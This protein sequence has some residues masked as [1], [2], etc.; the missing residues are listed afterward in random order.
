[1]LSIVPRR[2]LLSRILPIV[3]KLGLTGRRRERNSEWER[4]I[5]LGADEDV[6]DRQ[7]YVKLNSEKPQISI[8]RALKAD[9]SK[10]LEQFILDQC[11][12]F[13]VLQ[14]AR[15]LKILSRGEL[16]EELFKPLRSTQLAILRKS[17]EP[18]TNSSVHCMLLESV[19][20]AKSLF[21]ARPKLMHDA[22][23]LLVRIRPFVLRLLP[24]CAV[25]KQVVCCLAYKELD[26]CTP[27]MIAVLV[28]S[29]NGKDLT[30]DEGLFEYY[31]KDEYVTE[32]LFFRA[33][34]LL[35]YAAGLG[36]SN[37][38]VKD[39]V[40]KF[41]IGRVMDLDRIQRL[42][43]D[44]IIEELK[45]FNYSNLF[46]NEE[47]TKMITF[48]TITLYKR[49]VSK[50]LDRLDFAKHV[51]QH[52]SYISPEV[53]R[54]LLDELLL[55]IMLCY[56]SVPSNIKLKSAFSIQVKIINTTL[57][58]LA[59]SDKRTKYISMVN[60][61]LLE[62]LSGQ[63][64]ASDGPRKK[65]IRAQAIS[66]LQKLRSVCMAIKALLLLPEDELMID[67]QLLSACSKDIDKAWKII[68]NSFYASLK[69]QPDINLKQLD[70]N[71]KAEFPPYNKKYT[72]NKNINNPNSQ[73]E[74]EIEREKVFMG[75]DN[76]CLTE[77]EYNEAIK[78]Y[79]ASL[80]PDILS[81]ILHKE[82]KYLARA[83]LGYLE[84][85]LENMLTLYNGMQTLFCYSAEKLSKSASGLLDKFTGKN[86]IMKLNVLLQV[87]PKSCAA[88]S[89][90]KARF[91]KTNPSF[92]SILDKIITDPNAGSN[93]SAT[94]N[95]KSES[96]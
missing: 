63:E 3:S 28:N 10:N 20:A 23:A 9:L 15:A 92:A 21:P 82:R 38:V 18:Y 80:S 61:A 79:K 65:T 68:C 70:N 31:L 1:M 81:E 64:E 6:K 47:K 35:D 60:D 51:V 14:T 66:K 54:Q 69:D 50:S 86:E 56:F 77:D 55:E 12:H 19:L 62:M 49:D 71:Y 25:N 5:A 4:I 85:N 58:L 74:D 43:N 40:R 2:L 17:S 72:A 89:E 27:Q 84:E 33:V 29:L 42:T 24:R 93:S 7:W 45:N 36:D 87:S 30:K 59:L 94:A 91:L 37:I 46:T 48:L 26:L 8:N 76:I 13:T 53:Y 90:L 57:D 52:Y 11:K 34:E 78:D 73:K 96:M 16:K 32:D 22:C 41:L 44:D 95:D 67:R 88:F 83:C 75:P 39:P